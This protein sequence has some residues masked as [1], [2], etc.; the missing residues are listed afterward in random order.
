MTRRWIWYAPASD[1]VG[2]Q[3]LKAKNERME[4]RAREKVQVFKDQCKV[5]GDTGKEILKELLANRQA[6]KGASRRM[7]RCG[8]TRSV[9]T[10]DLAHRGVP[11]CIGPARES[12]NR[13]FEEQHLPV[14][15]I[16]VQKEGRDEECSLG[17]L[18]E[19]R[20]VAVP[21]SA[22]QQQQPGP[23]CRSLI[24]VV[25]MLTAESRKCRC[26]PM[27]GPGV[28]SCSVPWPAPTSKHCQPAAASARPDDDDV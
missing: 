11:V 23:K 15:E 16:T 25:L 21:G 28:L 12:S 4:K 10:R 7:W 3:A 24:H 8:S 14:D 5:A 26:G 9:V 22:E 2:E 18:Q 27:F 13:D 20:S 19:T 6:G 17:S 1:A